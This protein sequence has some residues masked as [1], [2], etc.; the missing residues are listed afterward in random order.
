MGCQSHRVGDLKSRL[1]GVEYFRT[2]EAGNTRIEVQYVPENLDLISRSGL[3]SGAVVT[4]KM[5]DSL[6]R[7]HNASKVVR[8]QLRMSPLR[9][10]SAAGIM[11]DVLYGTQF[12]YGMLQERTRDFQFGFKSKIW[13]EKNGRKVP[14]SVYHMENNF[15][16]SH[17]K[18]FILSFPNPS[19]EDKRASMDLVLDDLVP[20]LARKKI[21]WNL[22]VGK[23]DQSI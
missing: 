12:G 17:S 6:D 18:T 10:D 20:G 15:G 4:R 14:L 16:I 3:D 1:K 21:N 9:I 7:I 11:N 2:V 19:P 23:H 13:L 8:F 5:L 22:P